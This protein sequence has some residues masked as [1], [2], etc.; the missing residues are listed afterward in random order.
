MKF[1]FAAAILLSGLSSSAA[2]KT[3]LYCKNISHDD[4]KEIVIQE[5]PQSQNLVEVQEYLPD[6]DSKTLTIPTK[7]FSEGYVSLSRNDS[8]DRTLIRKDGLWEI[9]GAVGDYK[10]SSR[11]DCAE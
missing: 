9:S 7:D 8:G 1:V 2:T 6:G 5:S 11:A 3:L 4:L 10:Y